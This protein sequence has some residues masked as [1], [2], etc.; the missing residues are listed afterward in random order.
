MCQRIAAPCII[1]PDID[2]SWPSQSRRKFRWRSATNVDGAASDTARAASRGAGERRRR[3][4]PGVQASRTI[5]H[6][7]WSRQRPPI[8]R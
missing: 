4:V 3:R 6:R 7:S 8:F 5:A 2:T 1:V